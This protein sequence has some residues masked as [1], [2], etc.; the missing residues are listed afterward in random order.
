MFLLTEKGS[1]GIA[2]ERPPEAAFRS[3]TLTRAE[4]PLVSIL[5]V[6]RRKQRSCRV[7]D[8]GRG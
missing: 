7:S 2:P 8:P 6:I 1:I 4:Q 5:V 3:C